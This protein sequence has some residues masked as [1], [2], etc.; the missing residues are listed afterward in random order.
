[1]YNQKVFKIAE[2]SLSKNLILLFKSLSKVIS[3]LLL[4]SD[5]KQINKGDIFNNNNI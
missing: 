3:H 1:M 2:F 4:V 5:Q